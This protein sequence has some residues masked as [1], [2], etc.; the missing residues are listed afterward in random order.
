MEITWSFKVPPV[1][2]NC[3]PVAPVEG[4]ASRFWVPET[5]APVDGSTTELLSV[6]AVTT[7][8]GVALVENG[9]VP[10]LSNRVVAP[11]VHAA[12]GKD[13]AVAPQVVPGDRR[14][15]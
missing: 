9:A 13:S 11:A 6:T 14:H 3:T 15:L 4:T 1:S 2:S 8:T 10:K 5:V 7:W 12:E